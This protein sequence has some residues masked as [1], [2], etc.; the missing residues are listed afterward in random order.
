[1]VGGGKWG[2]RGKQ[3]GSRMHR[4]SKKGKC[5]KREARPTLVPSPFSHFPSP[6]SLPSPDRPLTRINISLPRCHSITPSL[7][8]PPHPPSPLPYSTCICRAEHAHIAE[9]RFCWNCIH[10]H[11]SAV[12]VVALRWTQGDAPTLYIDVLLHSSAHHT[13][14]SPSPTLTLTLTLTPSSPSPLPPL[15]QSPQYS[16]CIGTART[17]PRC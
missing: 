4:S 1:M 13:S 8:S 12:R 17:R 11:G 2:G 15:P 16:T 9:F 14:P 10:F 7:F 5:S 3:R 6:P